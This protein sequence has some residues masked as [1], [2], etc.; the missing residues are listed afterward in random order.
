[1]RIAHDITRMI[2]GG[3]QENT[4]PTVEG[5]ARRWGDEVVLITGPALGPEGSLLAPGAGARGSRM[6]TG[7]PEQSLHPA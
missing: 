1:M 3:A 7:P 4:L 6:L 2:L 5:L